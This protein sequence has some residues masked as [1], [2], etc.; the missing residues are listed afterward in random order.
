M[1]QKYNKGLNLRGGGGVKRIAVWY[2][3]KT[4]PQ[5][6]LVTEERNDFISCTIFQFA[7][8]STPVS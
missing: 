5:E 2:Q 3:G 1:F 6:L 4:F 7:W 8:M